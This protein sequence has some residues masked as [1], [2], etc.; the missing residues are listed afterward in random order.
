MYYNTQGICLSLFTSINLNAG[1]DQ[2]RA[3][4]K[5]SIGLTFI[6]WSQTQLQTSA[7]N[8]GYTECMLCQ[9]QHTNPFSSMGAILELAKQKLWQPS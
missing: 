4:R 9:H 7:R 5:K 6:R 1:R 3:K 8:S 2:T